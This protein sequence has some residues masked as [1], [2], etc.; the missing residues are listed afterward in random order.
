MSDH[1]HDRKRALELAEHP[2]AARPP[3]G[4]AP[5]LKLPAGLSRERIDELLGTKTE[6]GRDDDPL[7][8]PAG[9]T[10]GSIAAM[11]RSPPKATSLL[12]Q[13]SS[14]NVVHAAGP[15]GHGQ[16]GT[17]GAQFVFAGG[18]KRI[19]MVRAG[20]NGS[21][22]IPHGARG[23]LM[24]HVDARTF[25]GETFMTEWEVDASAEGLKITGPNTDII[26]RTRGPSLPFVDDDSMEWA[27]AQN[28]NEISIRLLMKTNDRG[29]LGPAQE[30][31]YTF[32][33]ALEKTFPDAKATVGDQVTATLERTHVVG[34]FATGKAKFDDAMAL[35]LRE[36]W[37]SLSETTRRVIKANELP[38]GK[39]I[40]ITGYA[41]TLGGNDNND[42][43]AE[44]RALLVMRRLMGMSG[45]RAEGIFSV[46]T[47]GESE[48]PKTTN[49]KSEE[50]DDAQYRKVVIT[51]HEVHHVNTSTGREE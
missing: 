30:N 3:E 28:G 23:T 10:E 2:G 16:F 48:S 22:S 15:G 51:I 41:S 50:R 37:N 7:Q 47:L 46:T 31:H 39:K 20:S 49:V 45:A 26:N 19:G 5:G 32:T 35:E 6:P 17:Q 34:P 40:E 36:F 12:G 44:E 43:L 42:V 38:G 14:A 9:L 1:E 27:T 21:I 29:P 33:L 24:Y 25:W 13:A 8:I 18:A 4:A 11:L